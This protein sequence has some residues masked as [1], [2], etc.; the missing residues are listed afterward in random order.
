MHRGGK[1]RFTLRQRKFELT[2]SFY[3]QVAA[4][5]TKSGGPPPLPAGCQNPPKVSVKLTDCCANLPDFKPKKSFG[6]KCEAA[7]KTKDKFC[8]MDDCIMNAMG[9]LTSGAC[10]AAKAKTVYASM[11]TDKT[12]WTSTVS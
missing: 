1:V 9:V 7:C 5:T 10:D 4:Q 8:C 2:L 11:V 6:D 12:A 3:D